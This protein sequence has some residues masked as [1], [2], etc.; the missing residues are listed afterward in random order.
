[1]SKDRWRRA[2]SALRVIFVTAVLF[3]LAVPAAY[4]E[5]HSSH[6]QLSPVEQ[7][8]KYIF[9]DKTLSEPR[10]QA[11]AACHGP[12]V[13]FTGPDWRINAAGAVYQ[14]AVR[15]RFGNRKPPSAAY[16]GD[17]PIFGKPSDFVGGMFWDGR[18]TGWTLG[19][20]LSEQAMG[21]FLNPLEQNNPGKWAVVSK[22]AKSRYACLFVSVW[23]ADA[24]KDTDT[25]YAY[26]ARSI[27]AYERSAEVSPFNSRYDT[28]L[29]TGTGLTAQE[30]NGLAL[31]TGKAQCTTCHTATGP[32][33]AFTDYSYANIGVPKNPLNPFYSE[34]EFNPAG[35]SWIDPG[36]GGFLATTAGSMHDYSSDAAA[37]MGMF[38]VP[39]LRNVDKRPYPM[40]VKAYGHNGYFKS[41][42]E[43]V[44]FYNTRDLPT[45]GWPAPETAANLETG[46]V[47]NLGLTPVEEQAIVAFLKTLSDR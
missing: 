16:A 32:N 28:Y 8:G 3:T 1:M 38:K 6:S 27:A 14:G 11:C 29:R 22:V 2:G 9:F 15:G 43:V 47:G 33:P 19:D 34:L 23:G 37:N 26:I 20:P 42:E 46:T 31:F 18:A 24:F 10:G 30:R 40:F 12:T 45:A 44:H 39:T 36:L 7:L 4:A 25:A 5:T 13:G 41:L 21:P 35:A 17:S